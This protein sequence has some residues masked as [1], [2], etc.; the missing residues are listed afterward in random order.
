MTQKKHIKHC[1]FSL[2]ES[3]DET[4]SDSQSNEEKRENKV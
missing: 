4:K 1:V 3:N 2:E